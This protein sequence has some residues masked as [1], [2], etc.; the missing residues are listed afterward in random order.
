MFVSLLSGVV[1]KKKNA[2]TH[3]ITPRENNPVQIG[4]ICC[5][6]IMPGCLA[7]FE[8]KKRGGVATEHKE[9]SGGESLMV[10]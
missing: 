6:V 1:S 8:A 10:P 4:L 5:S 3:S 2:M 7:V 9:A